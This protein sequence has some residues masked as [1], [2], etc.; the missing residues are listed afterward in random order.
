MRE[1]DTKIRKAGVTE[2]VRQARRKWHPH[3]KYGL[4]I[5]DDGLHSCHEDS[6]CFGELEQSSE[7]VGVYNR[8]AP[9]ADIVEDVLCAMQ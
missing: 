3:R 6:L 1:L 5:G 2:R 8:D 9:T 4:F 7:L